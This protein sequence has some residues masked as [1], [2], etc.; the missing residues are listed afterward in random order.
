MHKTKNP[1]DNYMGSGK[2]FK[3]AMEKYGETNF[4]K[5][6]LFIFDTAEEMFVKEK[7]IV[8]GEGRVCL[9]PLPRQMTPK[10]MWEADAEKD[11]MA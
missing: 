8:I 10:V 1:Y 6:V 4:I 11:T 7:E 5:E 2:L 9:P 3:R